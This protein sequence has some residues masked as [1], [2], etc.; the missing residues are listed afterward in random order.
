M[1]WLGRLFGRNS[2]D[3]WDNETPSQDD[4]LDSPAVGRK[5]VL[6]P[7]M[8]TF[9]GRAGGLSILNR[10]SNPDD[11]RI[12]LKN[13]FTPSQPVS[14]LHMFAGRRLL[15]QDLIRAIEDQQLHFVLYGDRGIGKTSILRVMSQIASDAGYLVRYISCGETSDFQETFRSIASKIPLLYHRDFDPTDEVAELGGT[16]ASL[17]PD[18]PYSVSHL[19]EI[20]S[21]ITGTRVI[22][23]LD[24]FDRLESLDFRRSIAELIKNL[25]DRATPLQLVIAGVASN[26]TDLISYIPSIRRNIIGMP[27]PNMTSD[28]VR[29]M[30]D[31]AGQQSGLVFNENAHEAIV[32]SSV[33]LPYLVGLIGQH[34]GIEATLRG[35]T[36]V[37]LAD[38]HRAVGIAA[39]E[40]SRRLSP[41]SLFEIEEYAK[42]AGGM[43]HLTSLAFEA[44]KAG[45]LIREKDVEDDAPEADRKA[46]KARM[47]AS[48]L[49]ERIAND[50]LDRWRFV[51]DGCSTF[52]WLS[53]VLPQTSE[54][55]RGAATTP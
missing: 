14:A 6:P 5:R 44:L 18:G 2:Q 13:A 19:S 43:E 35:S 39:M 36:K 52:I 30:L 4:G 37:E 3:E 38:V 27:V 50:P 54:D 42:K 9:R 40:V 15:L 55:D 29:E 7:G 25:S 51:E 8:P 32:L 41:T 17:L 16:L 1:G 33:G 31:I 10:A 28:E 20:L 46:R 22:I 11:V 26:L 47:T 45:G 48:K 49:F 53:N 24:E 23:M 34:A 12:R 21:G